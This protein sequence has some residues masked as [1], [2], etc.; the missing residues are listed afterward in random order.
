MSLRR[1]DSFE[2]ADTNLSFQP[3]DKVNDQYHSNSSNQP[4][5]VYLQKWLN[6]RQFE[7]CR[8]G[9]KN[10]YLN[11]YCALIQTF[12]KNR[13]I[14]DEVL[15]RNIA[16]TFTGHALIWWSNNVDQITNL[17]KFERKLR[18]RFGRESENS[19]LETISNRKQRIEE[20]LLD[21]IDDMLNLMRRAQQNYSEIEQIK[22]I[23]SGTLI[24]Y[25]KYLG[26]LISNGSNT[27]QEF[28]DK[29]ADY[30]GYLAK[31]ENK[32]SACTHDEYSEEEYE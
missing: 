28:T 8:V 16:T 19:I 23:T 17:T 1:C 3:N 13:C 22:I 31:R 7:G 25:K 5:F 14:S 9:Q 11:E 18:R 30:V 10:L 2:S 21:Y 15:L 20:S 6:F 26:I 12:Q 29:A 32:K 4:E 24:K 27:I